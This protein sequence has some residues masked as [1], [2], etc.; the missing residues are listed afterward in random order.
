MT[1]T[2][3]L[4]AFSASNLTAADGRQTITPNDTKGAFQGTG[5][6]GQGSES[7]QA[8]RV[9]D[10][11]PETGGGGWDYRADTFDD[12][13]TADQTLAAPV[14][15]TYRDGGVLK[16]VTF[17]TGTRVQSEF[18]NTMTSGHD[19]MGIRLI[20]PD[21]GGW[22]TAGYYVDP[23]PGA[24]DPP[25][26]GTNYGNV[27]RANGLGD[28]RG[29]DGTGLAC[30]VSGTPIATPDGGRPIEALRPGDLVLRDGGPGRV[31]W[32]GMSVVP[33][34]RWTADTR[35]WPIEIAAG[36]LGNTG[37]L[38]LSPQHRLA[39]VGPV[40]T[41]SLGVEAALVPVEAFLR[42]GVP[43]FRRRRPM[44]RLR[45]HHLAFADHG[46]VEVQ[47]IAAESLWRAEAV[48][49]DA[50]AVIGPPVRPILRVREAAAL[51]S[52]GLSGGRLS[53]LSLSEHDGLASAFAA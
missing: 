23:P 42:A 22:V 12:G 15:F 9:V 52:G 21:T 36:A 27:E 14:T 28:Y 1:R 6:Y 13:V 18:A 32:V 49:P 11:D 30:F 34:R 19:I 26:P 44:G 20:H 39:V 43:G 7:A 3:Q 17:P 8:L 37:P 40:L 16:T 38:A 24:P 47:G 25:A 5:P 51:L 46:L 4:A 35:L 45:Y 33:A 41:V 10:G 2:Y 53:G 50:P 29:A 31:A 48:M